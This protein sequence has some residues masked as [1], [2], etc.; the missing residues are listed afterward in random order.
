MVFPLP[1]DVDGFR[2]ST[3]VT[4]RFAETD[5]QGVAHNAVYLVWYEVARVD[6]LARFDGATPASARA[7][8]RL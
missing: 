4:V 1:V 6:Y 2:F 3:E 7:A 5:A 8:S